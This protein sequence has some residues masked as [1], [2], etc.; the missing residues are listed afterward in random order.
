MDGWEGTDHASSSTAQAAALTNPGEF[1]GTDADVCDV[2]AHVVR[3]AHGSAARWACRADQSSWANP[4]PSGGQMFH[5]NSATSAACTQLVL[6]G[7]RCGKDGA[8]GDGGGA[9]GP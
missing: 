6:L 7:S 3:L 4:L 8:H 9:G 5:G 2:H 1:P